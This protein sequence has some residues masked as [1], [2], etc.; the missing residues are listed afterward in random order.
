MRHAVLLLARI[1]HRSHGHEQIAL[2]VDGEGTHRVIAGDRHAAHNRLGLARRRRLAVLQ[3]VANDLVVDLRVEP[4]LVEPD[5]SAA[6]RALGEGRTEADIDVSLARAFRVLESDQKAALVRRVVA[7]IDATPGVD[8]DGAVG[9]HRKLAGVTDLVG[10]DGRAESA[11]RLSP[12]SLSGHFCSSLNAGTVPPRHSP[13]NA[14]TKPAFTHP[15]R[16]FVIAINSL[17][18]C[19]AVLTDIVAHG[20]ADDPERKVRRTAF[21]RLEEMRQL[22]LRDPKRLTHGHD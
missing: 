6:V 21:R 5:T 13:T 7:V 10:K 8:I 22:T 19:A 3:F 12:E 11:G 18:A 1:R 20:N 17:L 4:I 9:R 2:R 16:R 14:R 15:P